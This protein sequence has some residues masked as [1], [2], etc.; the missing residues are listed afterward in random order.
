[1]FIRLELG[2]GMGL[3][4]GLDADGHWRG[5]LIHLDSVLSS[6]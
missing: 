6:L 1:M 5:P 2:A 3:V 4:L